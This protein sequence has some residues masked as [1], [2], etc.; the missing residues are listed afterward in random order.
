MLAHFLNRN[1]LRRRGIQ[2][3]GEMATANGFIAQ[4]QKHP[5]YGPLLSLTLKVA[6]E[7]QASHTPRRWRWLGK[8]PRP[9]STADAVKRAMELIQKELRDGYEVVE[10]DDFNVIV[11]A[12]K[13]GV[14]Y[15]L[16]PC[17]ISVESVQPYPFEPY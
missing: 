16:N 1:E 11:L 10:H 13:T 7:C 2:Q 9:M 6:G 3:R 5:E 12:K 17:W 14:H 4:L 15:T 8:P